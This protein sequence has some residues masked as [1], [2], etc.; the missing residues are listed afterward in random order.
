[1]FTKKYLL[2]CA[3][4]AALLGGTSGQV[5][6]NFMASGAEASGSLYLKAAGLDASGFSQGTST[7]FSNSDFSGGAST[8]LSG[9]FFDDGRFGRS[10]VEG[11]ADSETQG[12]GGSQETFGGSGANTAAGGEAVQIPGRIREVDLLG[13]SGAMVG[14]QGANELGTVFDETIVA[15]DTNPRNGIEGAVTAAADSVGGA[16][17]E[18]PFTLFAGAGSIQSFNDFIAGLGNRKL[19]QNP[20]GNALALESGG[21]AALNVGNGASGAAGQAN[22]GS[23]YDGIFFE[24][25]QTV[26]AAEA[27]VRPG[28]RDRENSAIAGGG[29]EA[30]NDCNSDVF[31]DFEFE[32]NDITGNCGQ[33]AESQQIAGASNEDRVGS[34]RGGGEADTF[35]APSGYT[36][37]LSVATNEQGGSIEPDSTSISG[38]L[39]AGGS[40]RVTNGGDFDVLAAG[41]SIQAQDT[42]ESIGPA[43]SNIRD[44]VAEY[45]FG[46]K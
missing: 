42:R 3:V 41:F 12:G 25:T 32:I 17:N 19:L 6:P 11:E 36:N 9:F 7:G 35:N 13:G 18:G 44:I 10:Y 29:A 39:S 28:R 20:F 38:G 5:D 40:G 33:Y 1:M 16:T 37:Q 26:S 15:G 22:F 23:A 34:V 2:A 31:A 14:A 45:T 46:D 43:I 24:G 8:S 27:G 21:G 4:A 30:G